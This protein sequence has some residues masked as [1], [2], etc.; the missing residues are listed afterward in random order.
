MM[1]IIPCIKTANFEADQFHMV[2]KETWLLITNFDVYIEQSSG[3]SKL[4]I[5]I[6]FYINSFL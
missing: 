4:K 1:P 2:M 6:V 5:N 3:K